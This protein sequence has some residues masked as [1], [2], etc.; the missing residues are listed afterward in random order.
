V[1]VLLTSMS[2]QLGILLALLC[3]FASNLAFLYKHRGAC[4]ACTVDIR[5]PLRSAVSL[6]SQ[7]WF[8]IGMLVGGG[9]WLL[10]VAAISLAPLSVVQAVLSGG[11]VLLAV[12]ADRLFGFSV[13]PRQWWGLALTCVGLILL[14]ITLPASHGAN[15]SFSVSA[16]VAFEAGLFGIGGLFIMGPRLGGP[17][18][19]HGVML[20]AAAGVLFGVCNIGVKAL[21]GVAGADGVM[22]IVLS[23]WLWVALTGS[24]AAF[25]ASARSLQDGEAVAVI[26]ITG[27]AANIATI[28]G[29]IIVFGDPMPS[30]ALGIAIQTLAFV[31]VIVA[32]ALTPG[33]VRAATAAAPAAA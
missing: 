31:L 19:H 17:A 23:P 16:M 10:H 7:R 1:G 15:S 14:G 22:G 4:S 11:L 28:G 5:H 26:A 25:Y 20:A 3:A 18:E 9:A 30:D 27:T 2:L 32:S 6:W 13:G 24:A 29:G 33:P 21:T 8:A 12:M